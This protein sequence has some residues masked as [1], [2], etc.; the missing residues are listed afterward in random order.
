MPAEGHA[1]FQEPDIAFVYYSD[2]EGQTWSRGEGGIMI[3]QQGGY[4]RMWPCDEPS[5][6]ETRAG[7][8]LLF[9][10]TI[11]GRI[12][13]SR[14]GPASQVKSNVEVLRFTPGQ[15]FESGIEAYARVT[16]DQSDGGLSR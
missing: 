16:Q 8:L 5:V 6:I 10:R 15:R 13:T 14:S 11:L 3:W 9:C 4:G 1:H 2:D 12:Y 7:E